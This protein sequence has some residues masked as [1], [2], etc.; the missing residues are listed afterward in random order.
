MGAKDVGTI[1]DAVSYGG[2]SVVA[3]HPFTEGNSLPT[4]SN[5]RPVQRL[6]YDGR[7]GDDGVAD[8]MLVPVGS[9]GTPRAPNAP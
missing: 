6:P 9:P 5:S 1:A 8:F 3:G 7:D 4:M 2:A